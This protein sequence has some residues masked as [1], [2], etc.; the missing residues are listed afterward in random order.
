MDYDGGELSY[1]A[2]TITSRGNLD[3]ETICRILATTFAMLDV[4]VPAILAIVYG[5]ELPEAAIRLAEASLE[6]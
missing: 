4:Y 2:S 3:D 6:T 1:H 5:N